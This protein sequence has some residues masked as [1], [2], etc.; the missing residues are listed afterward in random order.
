LPLQP[1]TTKV[2]TASA[3]MALRFMPPEIKERCFGAVLKKAQKSLRPPR[4]A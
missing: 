2:V 3:A 1:T 4:K